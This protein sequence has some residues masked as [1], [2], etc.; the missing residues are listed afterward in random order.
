MFRLLFSVLK[1]KRKQY[2]LQKYYPKLPKDNLY[3]TLK[4][5]K[6][7]KHAQ[8]KVSVLTQQVKIFLYIH[9]SLELIFLVIVLCFSWKFCEVGRPNFCF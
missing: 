8:E 4:G 3:L 2:L 5:N 9:K 6:K 7:K 1:Q